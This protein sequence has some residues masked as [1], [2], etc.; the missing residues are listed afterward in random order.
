MASNLGNLCLLIYPALRWEYPYQFCLSVGRLQSLVWDMWLLHFALEAGKIPNDQKRCF[1]NILNMFNLVYS[2]KLMCGSQKNT[3][4]SSHKIQLLHFYFY[5]C[6]NSSCLATLLTS[7]L[8][9]TSAAL[10]PFPYP[11]YLSWDMCGL[12]SREAYVKILWMF[13]VTHLLV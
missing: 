3:W 7:F 2:L 6:S 4:C 9:W 8:L 13:D 5:S 10:S 12:N 11:L 1:P